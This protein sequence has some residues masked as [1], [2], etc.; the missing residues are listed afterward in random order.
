M[1]TDYPVK[2][3]LG[4]AQTCINT[5][6]N[7][8]AGNFTGAPAA[9]YDNTTDTAYPYA[10]EA[11]ATVQLPAWGGAPAAGTLIELWGVVQNVDGAS[12]DTDAPATTSSGGA[13]YFGA[14]TVAA[15]NALQRRTIVIDMRG[16]KQ[17]DFYLK[18]GTAQTLTN[19]GGTN[20]TLKVTPMAQGLT[21]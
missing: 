9:T 11:V 16:V 5:S 12:D 10:T 13:R 19:N 20:C 3:F 17:V 15:A 7:T 18:N 6:T 4:T 2:F 14:F 21:I 8:S 1:P